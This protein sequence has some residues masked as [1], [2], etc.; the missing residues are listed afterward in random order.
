MLP[1][2]STNL[3]V[4]LLCTD[5]KPRGWR[6]CLPICSSISG[7]QVQSPDRVNVEI[8]FQLQSSFQDSDGVVRLFFQLQTSCLNRGK[9]NVFELIFETV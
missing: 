4:Q 6:L 2:L 5:A 8:F 9:R 3:T 1:V 7:Q